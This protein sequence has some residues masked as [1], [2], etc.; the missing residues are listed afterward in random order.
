MKNSNTKKFT[1]LKNSNVDKIL[2]LKLFPLVWPLEYQMVTKAYLLSNICDSCDKRDNSEGCDNS[3]SS[4]SSGDS[5]P[6][7]FF[8]KKLFSSKTFNC[9]K[10][11]FFSSS[12]E[13]FFEEKNHQK[14][15]KLQL[16]GNS[17][18]QNV[19]KLKI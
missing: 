12:Q 9:T 17:K 10:K 16:W 19:M 1:K 15:L 8:T 18:T 11:N 14:I 7:L 5:D 4:D 6:K 3:D 2:K 13:T